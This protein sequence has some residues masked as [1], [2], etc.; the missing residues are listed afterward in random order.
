[1][2]IAIGAEEGDITLEK[3]NLKLFLNRDAN[4]LF[5]NATIDFIDEQGFVV[6]GM[7]GSSC[8]G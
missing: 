7:P 1:M 2:D 8:C 6:T 5:L 4:N 3:D